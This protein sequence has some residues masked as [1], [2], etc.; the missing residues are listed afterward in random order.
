M[1][2]DDN[3]DFD[4][5][6][7]IDPGNSGGLAVY[8][9]SGLA[10]SKMPTR[11]KGKNNETDI[12]ELKT[13]ID[14]QKEGYNPIVFLERVQAFGS[15]D[16][17]PGKAYRITKM[18]AN[19]ESL[20]TVLEM[21]GVPYIEVRPQDWQK[22]LSLWIKGQEKQARKNAY[23]KAAAEYYPAANVTLWSADAICILQFGRM[24]LKFDPDWIKKKLGVKPTQTRAL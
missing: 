17:N 21:N 7:G 12:T 1:F 15:E 10:V 24:K 6:I 2:K 9:R 22:Y 5:V 20:K 19:Y 3:L 13:I 23:K 18:L 14:Q 16:N 4:K 11:K 8:G